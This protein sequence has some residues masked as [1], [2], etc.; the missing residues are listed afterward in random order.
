MNQVTTYPLNRAIEAFTDH[1]MVSIQMADG[2]L[3][4]P[5]YI[6]I[7]YG[8]IAFRIQPLQQSHESQF[9]RMSEIKDIIL[10]EV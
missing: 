2:K 7:M 10:E 6:I 4:E 1:K 9:V 5:G 8:E 3:L